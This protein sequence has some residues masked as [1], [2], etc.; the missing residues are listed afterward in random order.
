MSALTLMRH[1]R[2]RRTAAPT[3]WTPLERGAA[4]KRT[5]ALRRVP[6]RSLT[7][8][9]GEARAPFAASDAQR[10]KIVGGACIVCMQTKGITPAHL[11]PRSL[12]GCDHPD[13]TV[14]LCWLHH[15]AYDT[16][17]LELLPFLEPR[18]RAEIA[19]AVL[20]LGLAGA[21]RRLGRRIP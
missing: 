11:V 4:P 21:V 7:A 2:L 18:W 1:G 20:H 5:T 15:R 8:R 19:H 10:Q 6:L 12:G 13:C 14:A 3:R 17:R 9:P 16:G